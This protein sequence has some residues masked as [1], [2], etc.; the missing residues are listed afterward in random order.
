V[1]LSVRLAPDLSSCGERMRAVSDG[2]AGPKCGGDRHDFGDLYIGSACLPCFARVDLNAIRALRRKGDGERHQLFV[3][4]GIAPSA[5][6]AL[7]KAQKACIAA[8]ACASR[9]F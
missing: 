4:S 2:G 5:I 7:S 1:F 3:F 8:G 6:A 9:F